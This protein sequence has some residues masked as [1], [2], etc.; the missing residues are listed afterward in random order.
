MALFCGENK[1]AA[2]QIKYQLQQLAEQL[3]EVNRFPLLNFSF[4]IL[5]SIS[6]KYICCDPPLMIQFMPES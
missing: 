6:Y 2:V 3:I 1:S 4:L 5:V